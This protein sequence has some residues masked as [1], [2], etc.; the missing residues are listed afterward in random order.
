L[1]A[2]AQLADSHTTRLNPEQRLA[3]EHLEGPLLV[4]A[5]AGSGKTRV[6]TM[7]VVR[8]IEEHGV[9][10]ERIL[11]VTFTNKAAGEMKDRIRRLLGREPTGAWIGTFHS[12]GARLLRRHA[13]LMGFDSAF[14]IFDADQSLRE[15]KR[16]M[17]HLGVDPKKWQPKAVRGVISDAKNRLVTPEEYAAE[18]T[19]GFDPFARTV[20][21]VFPEYQRALRS[22]NALDFDDLLVS[23][24]DLFDRQPDVLG[25]YQKRFAFMLVDEYQDTNRA[26]FRFLEA[27]AREHRNLMVVGDDDQSIYGWRGADIRN[28][29]DFETTFPG[30]RVVRLE[31][32]YRSTDTILRAANAVIRRN[33]NRKEKT[34][35]TDR[36]AGPHITLAETADEVDEASWIA[37]RIERLLVE[38]DIPGYRAAAVLYRTNAHS[39]ALEDA[40]RRR[41]IP[42][43]IVGGVRFYERREI[44]DV[45][46]YLRLI[47]NP[48]DSAAFE[49]VVNLP[50]RG[51]G[52]TTVAALRA[53]AERE[54]VSLLEA[55]APAQDSSEIPAGGRRGLERFAA[56]IQDFSARAVR[57]SVGPLIE[58]LVKELGLLEHLR[59]EG[60]EGEDR[61]DNVQELV[62]GAMDFEAR[63]EDEWEGESPDRFTELDLFLQQVA[64]VTDLDAHNARAEAVTLM[65]LHN[66][67]GLEYP[68]V[69]IAGLEDGLFPLSR[70]YDEPSELEE[71]RRLFYV[72]IT[73]AEDRL[74]L[75]WARERR[76]AGDF[77]ICRVSPFV[78]DVP[79]ELVEVERSARLQ[80]EDDAYRAQ[81]RR[82]RGDGPGGWRGE[83]SKW[84]SPPE[85]D[86]F[87]D[88]LNQDRARLVRGERVVHATFGSGTIVEVSGFGRDLRVVV[89]FDSVGVKRLLARY[90]ELERGL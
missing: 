1:T 55:V 53:L 79:A 81:G 25:R 39:R 6:L 8:L 74:F 49:R 26:Q 54:G 69:F 78:E 83:E 32:N 89:Q 61:A 77:M 51:V 23:T 4:L 48:Q 60:P 75:T 38:G 82:P 63:M 28:I 47:S 52:D 42:Y 70:A 18:H 35:R 56:L 3:V 5:G 84:E 33:V 62:A 67:K 19:E 80:R 76:R 71:E 30:T 57:L 34:L 22:Q 65:T 58:E 40:F 2:S 45:L 66:A 17:A 72:G 64:L 27:L 88:D 12:L 86:D 21:R 85:P 10:A 87:P 59:R 7:R 11:A 9:P 41:G 44:Q 50:R 15:V 20:A 90:A 14:T 29:L 46:A 68:A 37:D 24:V 16:V 13:G 43:Q 31:T 73:R 36:E